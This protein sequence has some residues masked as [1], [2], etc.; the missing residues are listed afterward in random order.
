[1]GSRAVGQSGMGM[2]M[3]MGTDTDSR[4]VG[5]SGS[6]TVGHGRG[7]THT[8]TAGIGGKR[9]RKTEEN[10][11]NKNIILFQE[12]Q[13]HAGITMVMQ[14]TQVCSSTLVKK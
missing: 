3:D 11:H 7:H 5:Q 13:G 2:D 10:V 1:M 6:R 9:W 12:Q 8:R 4:A 14:A